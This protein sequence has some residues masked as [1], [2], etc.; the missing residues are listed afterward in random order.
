MLAGVV[1]YGLAKPSAGDRG[2]YALGRRRRHAGKAKGACRRGEPDGAQ[3]EPGWGDGDGRARQCER[4]RA[5]APACGP[6]DWPDFDG[7]D[8]PADS[9]RDIW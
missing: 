5:V 8:L 1:E 4:G 3:D 6:V 9:D 2:A 7:V